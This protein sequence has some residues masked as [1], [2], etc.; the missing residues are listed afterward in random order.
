M[1]LFFF[2]Y[3]MMG[4]WYLYLSPPQKNILRLPFRP[5]GILFLIVKC[6]HFFLLDKSSAANIVSNKNTPGPFETTFS[7][8][9]PRNPFSDGTVYTDSQAF[10]PQPLPD[11]FTS[12]IGFIQGEKIQIIKIFEVVFIFRLYIYNEIFSYS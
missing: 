3:S 8:E 10:G 1:S 5:V 7:F 12:S 11:S 9:N 6:G 2:T 4:Y